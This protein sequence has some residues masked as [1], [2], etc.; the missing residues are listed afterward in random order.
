MMT[1]AFFGVILP[2]HPFDYIYNTLL[3]K[4]IQKPKLP[5]RSPQL[6]F[7]CTIATI[8]I[9]TIIF[10]FYN[11]FMIA[12]YIVGAVLIGVASLVA[13]IDLCIPSKIYN[14]VFAKK[15]KLV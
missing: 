13:T 2:N 7:A 10:L 11:N 3:S 6:K 12:G 8:F 4:Q 9:G 5:G 14:A 15:I 1:I